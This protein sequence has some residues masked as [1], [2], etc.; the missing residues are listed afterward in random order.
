MEYS[1]PSSGL[2]CTTATVKNNATMYWRHP[3]SAPK[4][5]SEQRSQQRCALMRY[6]RDGTWYKRWHHVVH[7]ISLPVYVVS[8]TNKVFEMEGTARPEYDTIS[9]GTSLSQLYLYCTSCV[10][11]QYWIHG[12]NSLLLI[13][14]QKKRRMLDKEVSKHEN[15]RR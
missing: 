8:R 10:L 6:N 1:V 15:D 14:L 11:V 13:I 5:E 7:N 12:S 2:C 3:T 4:T 9:T